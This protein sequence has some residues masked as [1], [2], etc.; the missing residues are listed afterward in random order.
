MIHN[1]TTY[2]HELISCVKNHTDTPFISDLLAH[3]MYTHMHTLT[4][5]T[6]DIYA[7]MGYIIP[8]QHSTYIHTICMPHTKLTQHIH[9]H[10]KYVTYQIAIET[11]EDFGMRILD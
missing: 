9:T 5:H 4:P 11:A 6:H 10:N 1:D 7:H 2:I 8:N 3:G